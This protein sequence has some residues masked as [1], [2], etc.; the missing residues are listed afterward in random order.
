MTGLVHASAA[1]L[2]QLQR[3]VASACRPAKPG[4]HTRPCGRWNVLSRTERDFVYEERPYWQRIGILITLGNPP[5][6][7]VFVKL[8]RFERL[9]FGVS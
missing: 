4:L 8:Q 1:S 3:A 9:H 7:G 2:P 5:G 6:R